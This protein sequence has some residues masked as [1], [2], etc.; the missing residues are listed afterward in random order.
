MSQFYLQVRWVNS[1]GLPY[2]DLSNVYIHSTVGVKSS[3]HVHLDKSEEQPSPKLDY[4]IQRLS[5]LSD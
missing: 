5:Q 2:K 1:L 4:K 3:A